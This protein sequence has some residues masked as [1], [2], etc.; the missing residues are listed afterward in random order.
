MESN[1]VNFLSGYNK[2]TELIK[3]FNE[4]KQ[5]KIIR[6]F[7]SG[8][9]HLISYFISKNKKDL[10]IIS[11]KDIFILKK[12]ISSF[13]KLYSKET[14]TFLLPS[15]Y[16]SPY[17]IKNIPLFISYER[18]R[19]FLSLLEKSRKKI[20]I[21]D[22]NSFLFPF[23]SF[24]AIK[25]YSVEIETGEEMSQEFLIKKL[26]QFSYSEKDLTVYQGDFSVRGHIIDL[27]PLGKIFP[28]RIDFE[29]D[30]IL[31]IRHFDPSTQRTVKKIEKIQ[32]LTIA[33]FLTEK[34]KEK[35]KLILKKRWDN[36][37]TSNLL[38]RVFRLWSESLYFQGEEL[39]RGF[40]KNENC[41]LSKEDK[42]II[43]DIEN[44]DNYIEQLE[45]KWKQ[46]RD[47]T[48]SNSL[49][50]PVNL[51]F[52][53]NKI[54][55]LIET[56]SYLEFTNISEKN[57]FYF[58]YKKLNFN[59]NS[60]S[61]IVKK[62][63]N[64]I[65]VLFTKE[66]K[67][68]EKIIKEI[69]EKNVSKIYFVK[70][71]IEDGF[72]FA[73]PS[74]ININ[75][76]HFF[77]KAKERKIERRAASFQFQLAFKEG[78]FVV[79][80]KYGIALFKGI[81]KVKI[82]DNY[83][84]FLVLEYSG[85]DK[86]Y[87]AIEDFNLVYRYSVPEGYIPVLDRLGSKNW[88]RTR[89]KVKSGILKIA[90]DLLKLYA[91]RKSLK[92]PPLYPDEEK[93]ALFISNFEFEE[94]EDQKRSWEEISYDLIQEKPMDRLLCGDVGF[95]KTEIAM[96]AAFRA[97]SN[98]K[99]IALLCPTTILAEQHFRNFK[100]RFSGFPY[101]IE[102][103]SRMTTPAKKKKIYEKIEKGEIDIIVG[104]HAL[105]SDK[106]KFKSLVLLIID[107]EQRFGVKHKD[108]ILKIK[109]NIHV[110][111]LSAT[112][113]PRTLN[114]ALSGVK[115]LSII[116]TPPPGRMEIATIVEEYKE[117][118]IKE[119]IKFEVARD[120]QVYI[121]YNSIERIESFGNLIKKLIPSIENTIIHSKL[122][123]RTIEER[124][125]NFINKKTKILISTTIIENGIDIENVNT[126][127]VI[128]A[129]NFG[130][131]QL[132]QLRGRIGR[133]DRKAYAYFL[134]NSK[135]LLN[136][137]AKKRLKA[138]REFQELGS[139]FRLAA[140]DLEIRG[141]GNLLG[142]EQ[143][144]HLRAVGF[145]YYLW[146][147]NKTIKEMKGEEE[148][149]ISPEINLPLTYIIPEAYIPQSSQRL[150]LYKRFSSIKNLTEL[151]ELEEELFDRFGNL[152]L[153][154]KN[155][156]FVVTLR[157]YSQKLRI[158]K[159]EYKNE[160][161]TIEFS[162]LSKIS[163]KRIIE[164][165]RKYKGESLDDLRISFFFTSTEKLKKEL[166]LILKDFSAHE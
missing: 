136:E 82:K 114:M 134:I 43:K 123:N 101:K 115:D 80:T 165:L 119:A 137:K 157:I 110:L 56:P 70:D 7:D 77:K 135:H 129:Q 59:E 97:V 16:S 62:S 37:L 52:N 22:P 149:E 61:E 126:L 85:G 38:K 26:R 25:E 144:G 116:E 12:Q 156:I 31:S 71:E 17:L 95:G 122:P 125:L 75:F 18:I 108:K 155:L 158:I 166:S 19:T 120:G 2:F 6:P 46:Y 147:L 8:F 13:L 48:I 50:P 154:I 141:A 14:E 65:F 30:E 161:L 44:Y 51:F 27:F 93:E 91:K 121:I 55:L 143:H 20:I 163:E 73:L 162:P 47:K 32:I 152:P 104:T 34:E 40:L 15:P 64:E 131:S 29:S 83:S 164:V 41:L 96:R 36:S 86:V 132:Y 10:L 87:V 103:L 78:D 130:L 146:L 9:S 79:H 24:S 105:L 35:L 118:I 88:T 92:A 106:I 100:K 140:M 39:F 142:K 148:Y 124:M 76:V 150:A 153:E 89:E 33:E 3:S 11:D 112:P 23:P 1:A 45:E 127:I 109:E 4:K 68:R 138:I 90:R 58:P 69:D 49:S 53:K 99:Q 145:E 54:S 102:E 42:I 74:G 139:G 67:I 84:E 159:M 57:T 117:E 98:K 60:F 128:D 63:K 21:A 5:A 113:I 151:K 94:T 111:S 133:G 66:E 28:V 160:K 107:E 81:K 72:S